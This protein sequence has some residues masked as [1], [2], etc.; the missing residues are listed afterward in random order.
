[1]DPTNF[2]IL[3]RDSNDNIVAEVDEFSSFAGRAKFNQSG[4]FDLVTDITNRHKDKLVATGSGLVIRRNGL[5]IFSGPIWYIKKEWKSDW[6]HQRL[7]VTGITD[8]GLLATRV[9]IPEPATASPP[10]STDSHHVET[11]TGSTVIRTYIN[12]HLGPGARTGRPFPGI[13]MA[14]DPVVGST[15]TGRGRYDNLLEFVQDLAIKA[16]DLGIEVLNKVVTI[17]AP[18]DKTTS[19]ALS[20]DLGN[21]LSY[22]YTFRYPD[23]N[24][25]FVAGQNEGTARTVV[26]RSI[27]GSISSYGLY[28]MF[29]DQR[30]VSVTAELEAAGDA[31][32][33]EKATKYSLEVEPSEES[34][35][36]F[37]EH[38][39]LGDKIRARID[40]E[41]FDQVV[42]EVGIKINRDTASIQPVLGTVGSTANELINRLIFRDRDIFEGR[43][44]N[45]EQI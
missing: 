28:E 1:M 37:Q 2:Q 10:Y 12:E 25:A 36:R 4:T 26:E 41:N 9:V 13:T 5:D 20:T 35:I 22:R 27:S 44:T 45:I 11:G 23:A 39:K 14:V 19:I 18:S 21:L 43:M 38:Y 24:Y 33:L 16:G 40:G 29:K 42:R 8:T 6:D 17:Y 15:I 32:L 34:G 31:E 30:N 3:I 7:T